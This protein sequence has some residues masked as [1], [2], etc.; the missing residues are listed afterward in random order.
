MLNDLQY[1]FRMLWKHK[2][3]SGIALLTLALGIGVN[4]AIFS[5]VNAVV[6][7]PLPYPESEQLMVVWG[8]LHKT[9]LDEIEASALEFKDFRQQ[10]Q[11]FDQI[12]AYSIEGFN[13]T[14][15]DQPERLRGAAVSANLFA[16]LRVQ[17]QLGRSFLPDED[18]LGNDTRVIL[19]HSL[20]QRRFA[21]DPNIINRPIQLDGRTLTVVGVMPSDFHFPDREIEAWIPLAFTPDLLQENN[22]GSH[23]LNVVARLKPGITPAQGQADLDTVTARLSQEHTSTYPSGF[24]ASIRSLHEE[25]VGNLRRAM[26]VLLGAVGLVL[27]IACANVAHLRLASATSRYREFAIRAALGANRARVVRQ[28]LTE[29][30][31]LSFIGGAVGFA[32]ALWVVRALVF[33]MPKDTPRLE[34]IKLDYRVVL[35]TL[36]T[37][38][39]TGIVFGLA[40]S[41]QAAR[42]NLNDVLKEAGRGGDASRRLKLRNLLVISEFALSLVLLIGAGLMVKSLLR[43]QE[44]KPGFD[45]TNLLTMRIALPSTKY[46]TF[47][48]SHAFFQQLLDQ[49]EARPEI[50]S[51]GA[52]NLL[53]FG[54]SGGDRSFSIQDQPTPSGHPRPDEQVRFV[55]P[56]YFR[57]MAIP[58]LSGRDFTRRDL[59]DTPQVAIVNS[60]LARKYWP[61]GNALGKRIAF[62]KNNPKWYEIV[63]IVGNVKHRGLDIQD[64]A[65]LYI[66]AFQPLFAD[67][68]VPALYFAVR[69]KSD[70]LLLAPAMRSEVAAL[71]R[72]QPIYSLMTMDQRISDSIAPRRFNMFILGLF[73]ALALLLAA[74]GIYGIMA[75]S[76]VQ[77]TH[78][79]GVRM[80]LG[81]STQD[82][83]KL[84]MR[85]GFKLALIGI[86]V[87]LVAAFAA[88]RV[89]SSLLYEVSARDP[90]IFVLDAILLAIAALLA[91]YIPARRATNV[92]PLVALRY[93]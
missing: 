49:L 76:V 71:D 61:D 19:S 21:G 7:R 58:L 27:L 77:R 22:R 38:L 69:T 70:P 78:E 66:P 48:Q 87:G 89:L 84:V 25:M 82:V 46:E 57:A 65:E 80:A 62:Q 91:C 17:P 13:L 85:N 12:A 64:H 15:I 2:S 73:A 40:P 33:L 79:I 42:T 4:S 55:T 74:I 34:E 36:G 41:F 26:L 81:A 45:S 93:E 63:G 28:F 32:L 23:F 53:P 5:V 44:V 88:T 50:E 31:L 60:A 92:D 56:G 14:G 83:L 68:N 35:F 43:L 37:S 59:P 16:T 29:S 24:S 72:D 10:C 3:V 1:G 54:G 52:I 18:Q 30:L 47:N 8:N 86:A 75:F 90:L 9:G 67:G 51:V 11:A 6:L 39:L 20:W